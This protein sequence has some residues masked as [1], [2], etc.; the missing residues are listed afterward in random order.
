M[1]SVDE[2]EAPFQAFHFAGDGVLV[3]TEE[4]DVGSM[5]LEDAPSAE[6]GVAWD[7]GEIR[8]EVSYR[9]HALFV[10]IFRRMVFQHGNDRIERDDDDKCLAVLGTFGDEVSVS[11]MESV[12]DTEDYSS[13]RESGCSVVACILHRV[14]VP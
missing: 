5:P 10:G 4:D 3:I 1:V 9:F 7:D 11:V 8:V 6:R 2:G 12:E 14:I 13:F